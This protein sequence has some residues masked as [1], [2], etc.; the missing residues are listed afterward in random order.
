A[1]PPPRPA[2]GPAAAGRRAPPRAPPRGPGPPRSRA[3]R[4]S[5][6]GGSRALPEAALDESGQGGQGRVLVLAVRAQLEGGA[7]AGG[8]E[9][10]AEDG[11]AVHGAP[12]A[13]Q[14][15]PAVE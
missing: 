14:G 10:D 3:R 8:Q 2:R 6:A 11:L 9:Q 7:L 13:A 4:R 15:D 12:L 1:P 5:R